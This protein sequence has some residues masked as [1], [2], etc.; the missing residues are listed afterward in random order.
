MVN[1]IIDGKN[2]TAKKDMAVLEAARAAGLISPPCARMN[3]YRVPVPAGSASWKL[4]KGNRTR[5]VTSC[6]YAVEEGLIVDT[7]SE[8]VKN[9]RRLVMELLLA[10][11]PRIRS[12]T[13]TGQRAWC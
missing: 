13:K 11:L 4:K 2:V 8:R 12:F 3:Q 5:I 9:V 6:L 10:R 7:K 1:L